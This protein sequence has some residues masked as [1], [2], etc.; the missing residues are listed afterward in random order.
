M[1]GVRAVFHWFHQ[2]CIT[3]VIIEDKNV[4][5]ATTGSGGEVACEICG[6]LPGSG[7]ADS[8]E[9]LMCALVWAVGC[10]LFVVV[11]GLFGLC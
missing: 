2:D 4:F 11:G 9:D 5:V 10:W 7:I 8:G 6:D 3:V 1:F